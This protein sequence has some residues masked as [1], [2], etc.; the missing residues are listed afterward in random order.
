VSTDPKEANT[1]RV[2]VPI[3]KPAAVRSKPIASDAQ[4]RQRALVIGLLDNHKHN[5]GKV[6]DRLQQRLAERF[7]TAR[8]VRMQ[9]PEAGKPA[10]KQLIES[11]A[12]ECRAVINGVAD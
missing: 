3:G 6:L 8:F 11:L 5:T 10:P 2:F 7:E 4:A 9:K 1:I 12:A